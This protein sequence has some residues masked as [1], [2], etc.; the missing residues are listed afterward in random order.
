MTLQEKI[1]RLLPGNPS[2]SAL[3]DASN[4][5]VADKTPLARSFFPNNRLDV[6]QAKV[7]DVSG[8][9]SR[10]PQI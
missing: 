3:T 7:D 6:I 1:I 10:G 9:P 4:L 2:K 5:I 8:S